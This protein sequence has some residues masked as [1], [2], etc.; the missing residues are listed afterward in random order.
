VQY[1]RYMIEGEYTKAKLLVD[2]GKV[3]L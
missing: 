2:E 1:L 3:T